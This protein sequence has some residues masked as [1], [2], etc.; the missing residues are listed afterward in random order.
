MYV[1]LSCSVYLGHF[2]SECAD[3]GLA[4]AGEN[5]LAQA[6]SPHIPEK[7]EQFTRSDFMGIC[8]IME[9]EVGCMKGE[10]P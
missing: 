5:R 9:K 8:W 10:T 2:S 7:E 3:V 1:W 6:L 4:V